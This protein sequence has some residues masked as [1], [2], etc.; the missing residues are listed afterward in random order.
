VWIAPV[1]A[2]VMIV[3]GRLAINYSLK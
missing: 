2:Q 1:M 3:F